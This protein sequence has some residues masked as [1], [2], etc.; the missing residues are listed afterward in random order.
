MQ[1]VSIKNLKG[2]FGWLVGFCG[3]VLTTEKYVIHLILQIGMA[4]QRE[5]KHK[6][7]WQNW[8]QCPDVTVSQIC[9]NSPK[10]TCGH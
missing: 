5:V 4:K 1:C 9:A 2:F 6:G 10:N 8:E 3:G 7:Y